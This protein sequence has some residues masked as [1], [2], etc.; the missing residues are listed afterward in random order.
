MTETDR[1]HAVLDGEL[2]RDS[3]QPDELARL[4]VMEA[5]LAEVAGALRATPVPELTQRVMRAL[6]PEP[7]PR[8]GP[9][10]RVQRWLW[11]PR[12]F[13]LTFRPAYALAGFATAALAGVLL[14]SPPSSQSGAGAAGPVAAVSPSQRVYVQFRLDVNDA[15]RVEVAGSF[16]GWEPT[17]EL[18]QRTPG[19]WTALV[20]LDPGVHDY[21]FV[22][23]GR[24]WIPDPTA[25]QV[26]DDFG[27]TNSRLFLPAP[28]ERSI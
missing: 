2:A 28:G 15:S 9:W 17:V 27:G 12:E 5:A 7:A 11:A 3:L 20:P 19:I 6:P 25:P 1:I 22:I 21:T 4:A 16:T 24:R 26:S 18:H 23:D 10:E 13:A 14:L 8:P